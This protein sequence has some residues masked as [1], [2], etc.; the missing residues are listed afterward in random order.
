MKSMSSSARVKS[1]SLI[2][3]NFQGPV[4][5]DMGILKVGEA[6]TATLLIIAPEE[7]RRAST[8]FAI[9]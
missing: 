8:T 2:L 7:A 9:D 3:G 6:K 4:I 1:A 5:I